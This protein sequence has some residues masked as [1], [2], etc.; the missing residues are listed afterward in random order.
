MPKY[1][2][3]HFPAEGSYLVKVTSPV[4]QAA[5]ILSEDQYLRFKGWVNGSKTI[6]EAFPDLSADQREI[7]LTGIGPKQWDEM[8][9][10]DE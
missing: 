6:Q 7:L 10:E 3:F 2:V 9:K 8:F 4:G 5:I 1:E